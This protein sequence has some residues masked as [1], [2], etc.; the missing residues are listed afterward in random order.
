I[1]G[2]RSVI[3]VSVSRRPDTSHRR[4]GDYTRSGQFGGRYR[5]HGEVVQ[6][7]IST[8]LRST[9]KPSASRQKITGVPTSIS[10]SKL[11]P[12]HSDGGFRGP[13]DASRRR[14]H[15]CFLKS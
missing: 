6:V 4:N 1:N 5:S 3:V 8:P 15:F 2:S 14:K 7:P 13:S 10:D 9:R 12:A 11:L